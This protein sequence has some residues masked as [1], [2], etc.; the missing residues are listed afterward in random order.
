M[1]IPGF[2][3]EASL[4][5]IMG[6]YR[7]KAVFGRFPSEGSGGVMPQFRFQSQSDPDVG[8]YWRCRANGGAISYAAGRS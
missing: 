1:N 7:G 8:V 5:P 2:N 6:I 4:G 3:A